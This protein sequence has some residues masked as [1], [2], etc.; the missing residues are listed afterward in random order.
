MTL[1]EKM[2]FDC[3]LN[4]DEQAEKNEKIADEYAI[5]ILERY[6]NSLFFIPLKEGEAKR[7]VEHIKKEKGL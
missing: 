6:H 4:T 5:E 1:K 3:T 2:Y 7:I